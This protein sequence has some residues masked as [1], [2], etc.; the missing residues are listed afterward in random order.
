[1]SRPQWSRPSIGRM[2]TLMRYGGIFYLLAAMEPAEYRP[3]DGTQ[4]ADSRRGRS[5]AMEPA[6]YRPDD[7]ASK[8]TAFTQIPPQWSR[9]SIGRMTRW[10]DDDG[11][12]RKRPQWSR[13]SIGRMTARGR[14]PHRGPPGR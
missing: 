4:E 3:D 12:Q 13:P 10:R 6:E 1:M 7:E 5:A 8:L 11:R 9:P 2:T 14:G